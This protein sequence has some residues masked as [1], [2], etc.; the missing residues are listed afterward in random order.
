MN[1]EL[2]IDESCCGY[3]VRTGGYRQTS[4]ARTYTSSTQQ[5]WV[6]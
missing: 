6:R 4:E 5:N 3:C 1:E 2:F